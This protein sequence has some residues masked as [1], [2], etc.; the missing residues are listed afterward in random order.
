MDIKVTDGD[1]FKKFYRVTKELGESFVALLDACSDQE[2]NAKYEKQ[3]NYE[4]DDR[5]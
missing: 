3:E 4:Y 1:G 2:E 5:K